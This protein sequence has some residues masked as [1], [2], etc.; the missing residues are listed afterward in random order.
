MRQDAKTLLQSSTVN[1]TLFFVILLFFISLFFR[2]LF[3]QQI[4]TGIS[5]DELSFIFNAKAFF[6]T[7]HTVTH[8]FVE[9]PHI[10][11]APFVGLFPFSLFWSKLP[12]AVIGSF[13]PVVLFF[14]S[15][16]LIGK[17]GAVFVGLVA[18]INPWSIFFS[19]TAY[20]APLAIFF[21]L[22]GFCMMLYAK[23]WKILF[24]FVPFFLGFYC[25][26]GTKVIFIPFVLFLCLYS[27]YV[28]H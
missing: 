2:T 25:Y 13:L 7:G 24:A 14:I 18:S 20:E 27:W 3:L 21:L 19:R 15:L 5:D 1:P 12:Y 8:P 16:K 23:S 6:L 9:I 11:M 26:Q 10:L 4:P 17:K 28:L 22:F